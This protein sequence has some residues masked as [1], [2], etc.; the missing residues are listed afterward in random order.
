MCVELWRRTWRKC[1]VS[2]F[3]HVKKGRALRSQ[4]CAHLVV[5]GDVQRR[6]SFLRLK[7][8]LVGRNVMLQLCTKLQHGVHAKS[9]VTGP[10]HLGLCTHVG[11]M[12]QQQP[13]ALQLA[14][15]HGRVQRRTAT[16]RACHSQAARTGRR[17]ISV[18][19]STGAR[20]PCSSAQRQQSGG[21]AHIV[22][23]TYV[24]AALQQQPSA[25]Q[26]AVA[27]GIMQ[28][29]PATLREFPVTQHR[30]ARE[31]M[32][33]HLENACTAQNQPCRRVQ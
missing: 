24:G 11:A 9:G 5:L 26:L 2:T 10:A 1:M 27:H 22:S 13:S 21:S 33:A 14:I 20:A 4:K 31:S 3:T 29:G 12:L 6:F 8:T 15:A 7:E 16:L 19:M 30:Q 18:S 32:S 28:R 25:L 23:C 17:R